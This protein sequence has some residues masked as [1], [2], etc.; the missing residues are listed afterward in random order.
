MKKEPD[1]KNK[2]LSIPFG[3]VTGIMLIVILLLLGYIYSNY[4]ITATIL[5]L[6]ASSQHGVDKHNHS[7][8][9]TSFLLLPS[10]IQ[11]MDW[12]ELMSGQRVPA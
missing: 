11:E 8:L 5:M 7:A 1:Y 9:T 3:M 12:T 10:G 6:P 4:V 2:F